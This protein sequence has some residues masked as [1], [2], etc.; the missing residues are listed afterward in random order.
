MLMPGGATCF[1]ISLTPK[2]FNSTL[3][4]VSCVRFGRWCVHDVQLFTCFTSDVLHGVVVAQRAAC[5][6]AVY[7]VSSS[8]L[9]P[10]H[11]CGSTQ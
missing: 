9:D 11:A 1:I 8:Q 5:V 2:W 3:T 7:G 10:M 6:S 4:C